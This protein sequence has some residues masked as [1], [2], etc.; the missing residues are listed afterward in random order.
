MPLLM[1]KQHPP[2]RG[3]K[4]VNGNFTF[5]PEARGSLGPYSPQLQ[6]R[7]L[8][9][10]YIV[11]YDHSVNRGSGSRKVHGI[12]FGTGFKNG[13]FPFGVLAD[14][15]AVRATISGRPSLMHREPASHPPKWGGNGGG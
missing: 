6:D 13:M 4:G 2:K 9:C 14:M 10:L 1:D 7:S 5:N 12:G 15:K 8:L 3:E 11:V